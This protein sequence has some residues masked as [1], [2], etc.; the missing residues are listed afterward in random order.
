MA[1]SLIDQCR[2]AD[3]PGC[4]QYTAVKVV[5]MLLIF[6]KLP[7]PTL[8]PSILVFRIPSAVGGTSLIVHQMGCSLFS[9]WY[10]A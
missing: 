5:A 9:L 8:R 1:E 4:Q 2:S 7:V 10:E 3:M 6:N